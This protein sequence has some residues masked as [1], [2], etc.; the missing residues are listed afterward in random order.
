MLTGGPP[1]VADTKKRTIDKI[2]K[3][4]LVLPPYLSGEA[5]DLIKRLLKRS[6]TNRLG[7]NDVNEIKTHPFFKNIDWNLVYRREVI[8]LKYSMYV[9]IVLDGSSLQTRNHNWRWHKRLRHQIYKTN[10]GRLSMWLRNECQPIRGVY[11]CGSVHSSR[12]LPTRR[13]S[14][15]QTTFSPQA[16]PNTSDVSFLDT[17]LRIFSNRQNSF[18]HANETTT[19]PFNQYQ[20]KN[21]DLSPMDMWFNS[22]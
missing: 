1:F 4:R 12:G 8:S 21:R 14:N 10:S 9:V 5:K 19:D 13:G 3:S 20:M 11:L 18:G 22:K 16:L 15:Q 7:A 6:S 2:L 17:V